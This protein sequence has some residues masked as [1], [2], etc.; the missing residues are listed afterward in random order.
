MSRLRGRTLQR[1]D[2]RLFHESGAKVIKGMGFEKEIIWEAKTVAD[3]EELFEV[4]DVT[5]LNDE[6]E[7]YDSVDTASKYSK[8]YRDIHSE[9]RLGLMDGYDDKYPNYDKVSENLRSYIKNGRTK[10]RDLKKQ[11]EGKMRKS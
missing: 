9:M 8:I 4:C 3:I 2:Y 10:I 11:A 6:E 5:E 7:I 1:I